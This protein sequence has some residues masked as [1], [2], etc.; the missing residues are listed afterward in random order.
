[1]INK[2]QSAETQ[3]AVLA[4]A[5]RSVPLD[6]VYIKPKVREALEEQ[7]RMESKSR[8]TAESEEPGMEDAELSEN[9]GD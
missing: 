5:I 7:W 3:F 1:M 6:S 9:E 8:R 4:D 2:R